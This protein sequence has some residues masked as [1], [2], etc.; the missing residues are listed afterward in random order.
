MERPPVP[1]RL[2]GIN[3]HTPITSLVTSTGSFT[4]ATALEAAVL[5]LYDRG[6]S[7]RV[8]AARTGVGRMRIPTLAKRFGRRARRATIMDQCARLRRAIVA[9][10]LAGETPAAV[11]R[12]WGITRE[13]VGAHLRRAHD[14]RLQRCP[15]N[16][17][18][19]ADR[20]DCPRCTASRRPTSLT[21]APARRHAREVA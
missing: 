8:I 21:P 2:P 13:A 14:P 16:H 12:H 3:A 11:G 20:V 5:R 18:R 7:L 19:S 4:G 9:A 15:A 10:V 17:W 6:Y 1:K